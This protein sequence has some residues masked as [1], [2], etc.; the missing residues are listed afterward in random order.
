M[1]GMAYHG[2]LEVA[3][4]VD[5]EVFPCGSVLEVG[6]AVDLPHPHLSKRQSNDQVII[7]CTIAIVRREP[8]CMHT[9]DVRSGNLPLCQCQEW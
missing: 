3:D 9:V 1:T 2:L 4:G 7:I 5:C 8:F 6:A